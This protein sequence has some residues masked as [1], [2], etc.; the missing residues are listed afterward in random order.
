MTKMVGF[1][2]EFIAENPNTIVLS[3]GDNYQGT[4]E[5]NLTYGKPVS[6]MMKGMNVLASA[7][8]NHEFD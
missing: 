8:G 1:V 3:G 7:V 5:S 6:A 2:N 4:A